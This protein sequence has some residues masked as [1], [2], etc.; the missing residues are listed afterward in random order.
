MRT[1]RS[2]IV[3]VVALTAAMVPLLLLEDR[4][5]VLGF[6]AYVM[7]LGLLA[8]RAV[9]RFTTT[10]EAPPPDSPFHRRRRL[11]PVPFLRRRAGPRDRG[12]TT[13]LDHLMRS[14]TETDGAFHFRLRPQLRDAAGERLQARHGRTIDDPRAAEL[15]GE[16]AWSHLRPDRPRPSDR[17][18]AGPTPETLAAVLAAVEAL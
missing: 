12:P 6:R 11:P 16:P 8:L 7:L 5:R 18:A 9:L 1:V 13:A 3:V 10:S 4:R 2:T 15:L 14:A 17:R